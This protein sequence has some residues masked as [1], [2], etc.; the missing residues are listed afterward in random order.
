[1]AQ[2]VE[3]I[4]GSG[5]CP[6]LSALLTV[7]LFKFHDHNLAFGNLFDSDSFLFEVLVLNAVVH[8]TVR[9]RQMQRNERRT[10]LAAALFAAEIHTGNEVFPRILRFGTCHK[11]SEIT[12]EFRLIGF[13]RMTREIE[14]EN[15]LLFFHPSAVTPRRNFLDRY[16]VR[17]FFSEEAELVSRLFV[18]L[19]RLNYHVSIFKPLAAIGLNGIKDACHCKDLD[20]LLRDELRA[21]PFDEIERVFER[22]ILFSFGLDSFCRC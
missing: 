20:N 19:S 16:F 9:R 4:E 8:R 22:T 17:R 10:V 12:L 1:M 5:T 15:I 6:G 14:A 18:F 7:R 11:S 13:Q 21:H 2:F 3:R